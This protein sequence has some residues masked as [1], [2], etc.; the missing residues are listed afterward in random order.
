MTN[1]LQAEVER[2]PSNF[3]NKREDFGRRPLS[4]ASLSG[5]DLALA[6]CIFGWFLTALFTYAYGVPM[7]LGGLLLT[8]VLLPILQVPISLPPGAESTLHQLYTYGEISVYM[9]EGFE[10]FVIPILWWLT[11]K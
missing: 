4:T 11:S 1:A 3:S 8:K 2:L 6:D 5:R 9:V 10:L 7:T